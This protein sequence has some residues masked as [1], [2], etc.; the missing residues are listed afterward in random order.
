MF[1]R[2]TNW[3][4]T[5]EPQWVGF[6]VWFSVVLSLAAIIVMLVAFFVSYTQGWILLVGPAIILYA[7]YIAIFKQ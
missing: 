5:I 2:F 7:W 1:L 3:T 4:H 6:V